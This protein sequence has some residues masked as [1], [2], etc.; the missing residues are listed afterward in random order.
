MLIG[1]KSFH[2]REEVGT[3]CAALRA[4]EDPFD[5]LNVY[6]TLRGS[7]FAFDD[8]TLCEFWDRSRKATAEVGDELGDAFSIDTEGVRAALD[9]LHRLHRKRNHQPITATIH[10]LLDAVRAHAGFALRPGGERVLA[11]VLRVIDLARRYE[12]ASATSFRSFIEFLEDEA[13]A[14]E[15][16]EAPLLE[17]DADGVKLM[18]VHKAKG[19]EF[20]V[21]ILADPT[22]KAVHEDGGQYVDL[23]SRICAHSLLGCAPWDLLDH[24]DAEMEAE[25]AEADRLAYV[26]ATR[27]R[28][29]LVIS[30]LGTKEWLDSW[31]TPLYD[32]IYPEADNMGAARVYPR[33]AGKH[34]YIGKPERA[35]PPPSIIPGW[36][37]ARAG[38]HEVLWMDPLVLPAEP[39]FR[40]GISDVN[41]L[42]GDAAP[43]VAAHKNWI[44]IREE[45]V[46]KGSIPSRQIEI[47]TAVRNIPEHSL[48]SVETVR[49][50]PTHAIVSD[51]LFG[52]LVHA[53]LQDVPLE[54]N[55]SKSAGLLDK[56]AKAHCRRLGLTDDD[57]RRAID[58]VLAIQATPVLRAAS[59]AHR[60]LRESPF[61]FRSDGGS[62]VAGNIDLAYLD[63]TGWTIVDY[64]TGRADRH[65]YEKQMQIYGLALASDR[66]P[67]KGVLLELG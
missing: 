47:A 21:V 60:I 34:T 14:G 1:S 15:T 43:G 22:C 24:E 66:Q 52:K 59:K 45:A 20:P 64:K 3:L 54:I 53:I 5:K 18:T 37:S 51:R 4:I 26:A 61:I 49:I 31:L 10:E 33:F 35:A 67:V 41:L 12:V 9:I 36:H 58:M 50:A 28:D 62:L 8:V 16:G 44:A 42:M 39:A 48:I 56:I 27:S 29:L 11:N 38:R 17:H 7:L 6:A 25:R 55:D 63:D 65:E 19:L 40:Q 46:R 23:D 2:D 32:A 30:G 13:A 57:L